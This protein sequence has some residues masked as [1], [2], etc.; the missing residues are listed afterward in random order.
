MA[1]EA[2]DFIDAL[3]YSVGSLD[4]RLRLDCQQLWT[5]GFAGGPGA[6]NLNVAF[7]SLRARVPEDRRRDFDEAVSALVSKVR[8]CCSTHS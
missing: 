5:R 3:L 4:E 6:A 7:R 8:S 1:V 2:L